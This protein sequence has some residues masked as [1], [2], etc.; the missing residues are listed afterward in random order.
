MENGYFNTLPIKQ[1]GYVNK[2]IIN[3]LSDELFP[4]DML[5]TITKK[6]MVCL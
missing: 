4:N 5:V 1:G 6:I 3:P 2:D